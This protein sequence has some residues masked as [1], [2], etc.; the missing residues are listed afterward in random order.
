[1]KRPVL[2][3]LIY[4]LTG[5]IAGRYLDNSTV[6]FG[7]MLVIVF[8]IFKV[9]K[10][11]LVFAAPIFMAIGMTLTA[12]S[13]G[14]DAV[15]YD[16]VLTVTGKVYESSY[17]ENGRMRVDIKTKDGNVR[18]MT[19]KDMELYTGDMIMAVGNVDIPQEAFMTVLSVDDD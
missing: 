18:V 6:L 13:L 10:R 17:S 5:I 2:I 15:I 19:D 3:I 16:E 9:Y 4:Y 7:M 11:K 12:S 14:D 8:V 1:M